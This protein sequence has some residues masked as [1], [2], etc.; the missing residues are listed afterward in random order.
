MK[1]IITQQDNSLTTNKTANFEMAKAGQEAQ[2]V[3]AAEVSCNQLL[4]NLLKTNLK[5]LKINDISTILL[6]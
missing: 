3:K 5:L 6:F 2:A 4:K 1:S